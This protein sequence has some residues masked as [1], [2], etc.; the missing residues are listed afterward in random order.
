MNLNILRA[1]SKLS[2]TPLGDLIQT[3]FSEITNEYIENNNI[4]EDEQKV[5]ND[6]LKYLQDKANEFIG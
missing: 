2:N 6:F 5:I 4:S 3:T 1:M